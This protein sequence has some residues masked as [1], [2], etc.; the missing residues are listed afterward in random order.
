MNKE[1]CQHGFNNSK[2]SETEMNDI[3]PGRAAADKK[4]EHLV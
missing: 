4:E 3:K 1:Y 2:E